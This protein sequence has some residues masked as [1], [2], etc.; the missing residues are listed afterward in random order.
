MGSQQRHDR[1]RSGS[2][3]QH[4]RPR[5]GESTAARKDTEKESFMAKERGDYRQDAHMNRP[6]SAQGEHA[7][8]GRN[9]GSIPSEANKDKWHTV[10]R[11]FRRRARRCSPGIFSGS[12]ARDI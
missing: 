10:R 3:Q 4:D 12:L 7:S 8:L 5:S 11:P 6:S 2:Q 1:P 9:K